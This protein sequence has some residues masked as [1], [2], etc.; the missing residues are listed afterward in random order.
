[1]ILSLRSRMTA[2]MTMVGQGFDEGEASPLIHYASDIQ[3]VARCHG[4][5]RV[6]DIESVKNERPEFAFRVRP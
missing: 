6:T 4:C 1:M 2:G 5:C 3:V